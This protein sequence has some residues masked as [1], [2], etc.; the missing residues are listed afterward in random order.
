MV[1]SKDKAS[2]PAY[3]KKDLSG[4][5][6]AWGILVVALI[7]IVGIILSALVSRFFSG[8]AFPRTNSHVG[9]EPWRSYP[10]PRLEPSESSRAIEKEQFRSAPAKGDIE[11]YLRSKAKEAGGKP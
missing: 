3:E 6:T 8:E 7:I 4:R 10:P 11:V 5:T 9:E 1:V 2:H